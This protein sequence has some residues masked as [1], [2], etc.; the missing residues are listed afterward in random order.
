VLPTIRDGTEKSQTKGQGAVIHAA[1]ELWSSSFN[2]P[3]CA[4]RAEPDFSGRRIP[5]AEKSPLLPV[6]VAVDEAAPIF[7]RFYIGT[8]RQ[9][10]RTSLKRWNQ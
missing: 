4:S 6:Q 1:S 2:H 3:K 8:S 7:V 10:W 9:P 5:T